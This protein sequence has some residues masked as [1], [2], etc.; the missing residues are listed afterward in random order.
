M[1]RSILGRKIDNSSWIWNRGVL[2]GISLM[3]FLRTC[4]IA[5]SPDFSLLFTQVTLDGF[6]N[7]HD[8]PRPACFGREATSKLG[9]GSLL[10]VGCFASINEHDLY[11][12]ELLNHVC[13]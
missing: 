9:Y 6:Y 11:V 3:L 2:L 8:S 7:S 5:L 4:V 10:S 1:K 12:M 13:Q